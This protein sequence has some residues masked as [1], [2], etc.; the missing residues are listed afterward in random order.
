MPA[1]AKKQSSKVSRFKSAVAA[2]AKFHAAIHPPWVDMIK[3]IMAFDES[4]CGSCLSFFQE[5]I[6]VHPDTRAGV[7]R[8]TIKK[9]FTTLRA[10]GLSSLQ[11]A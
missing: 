11:L 8:P 5:C 3:V 4:S 6:I 9:V 1:T 7:S 2:N 10:Y